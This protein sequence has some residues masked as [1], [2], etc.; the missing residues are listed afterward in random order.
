MDGC[1]I[2][3]LIQIPEVHDEN[4]LPVGVVD[5]RHTVL[6]ST[7]HRTITE[8]IMINKLFPP[9]VKKIET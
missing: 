6:P 4:Q 3:F 8:K 2:T 5:S 9:L 1:T 7:P